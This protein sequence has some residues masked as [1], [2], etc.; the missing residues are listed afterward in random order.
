MNSI[1]INKVKVTQLNYNLFLKHTIK[2]SK[3]L[4]TG[5]LPESNMFI[6]IKKEKSRKM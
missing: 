5:G 4:M 6:F 1:N 2:L 3:M